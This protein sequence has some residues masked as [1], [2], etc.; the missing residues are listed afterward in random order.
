[1]GSSPEAPAS[2]LTAIYRVLDDP[3]AWPEALREFCDYMDT[4]YASVLNLQVL[5]TEVRVRQFVVWGLSD[6]GMQEYFRLWAAKD[7]WSTV[8]MDFS[9]AP[10]GYI[11]DSTEACPDDILEANECYQNFLKPR[12]LHYGGCVFLL[13]SPRSIISLGT[14]RPKPKGR[15]TPLEFD[16]LE[17]ASTHFQKVLRI[18]EERDSLTTQRDL[19]AGVFNAS[20]LGFALWTRRAEC[21]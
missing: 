7:P 19:L 4:S 13:N 11:G 21:W 17:A 15:L 1:M 18:Q 2:L 8:G 5:R 6:E 20:G 12:D 9:A 16:R 14:L 10:V 3:N